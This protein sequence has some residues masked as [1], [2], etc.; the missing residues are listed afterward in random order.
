MLIDP[1]DAL[2][3]LG[4]ERADAPR[5]I[6]THGHYDHIGNLSH[7]NESQ[8]VVARAEAEF[9]ARPH[10]RHALFRHA[11]EESEL[12]ALADV[13]GEGRAVLFEDHYDVAPGIQV[14]RVGGHTPGQSVVVVQ[15]AAGPVV[16]ASDAVHYYEEMQRDM[17]FSSVASLVDM[18]AAFAE[19]KAMLSDGRAAQVVSGHDPATLDL[20]PQVPGPAGATDGCYRE[21]GLMPEEIG[22]I[23]LGNMG[24]RM[25][26][27]LAEKG[28][29]V[30]GYDVVPGL[31]DKARA[32]AAGVYRRGGSDG[33]RRA[34]L[35]AG[36]QGRRV[37]GVRRRRAPGGVARGSGDRRPEHRGARV[38]P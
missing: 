2:A 1:R 38:N 6:I 13:I 19:L 32:R 4:I 35:A 31:A 23:G 29:S 36:Q 34:A 28:R 11:V 18:Y 5:V 21:A 3:E 30:V 20:Y 9:W 27:R 12:Q 37:R 24:G 15:T 8:V 26:V 22:F 17:P 25:A 14:L 7:F 16:L 33:G 10:A